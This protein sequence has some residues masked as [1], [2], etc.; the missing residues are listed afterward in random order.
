M[1]KPSRVLGLTAAAAVAAAMVVPTVAAPAWF[2]AK[3]LSAS[4]QSAAKAQLAVDSS[5]NVVAVWE[6]YNGSDWI[7]Q[8]ARYHA[9]SNSWTATADLSAPGQAAVD[10]QVAVDSSGNAIAVWERFNG[11]YNVVQAARFD[12][13]SGTW[14]ATADLSASGQHGD[15]PSVAFS[16]S[17]DAVAL[18]SRGGIIQSSTFDA[19]SGT[20]G[21]AT[22][23][24]VPGLAAVDPRIAFSPSGDALGAW[25]RSDGSNSIVR[26]AKYS[27]VTKTWSTTAALSASGQDSDRVHLA[28]D[29]AGNAIAVWERTNGSHTIARGA[30][31][32]G[33][34]NSW[35]ATE[36]L[37]ASGGDAGKPRVALD[38]SGNAIA[39][40]ERSDG[41]NTIAQ[42]ARFNGAT[43]LWSAAQDLSA[44]GQ[45]AGRPQVAFDA[46]GEA[47][48]VWE[49][50][51][52]SD[53]RIQSARFKGGTWVS[54][55]ELSSAGGDAARAQVAVDA[56]GNAIAVWERSDGVNTIVQRSFLDGVAPA[57]TAVSIPGS[58]DVGQS[59]PMSI[60]AEDRFGLGSTTWDFGDGTSLDN[61][62]AATL[63][64]QH[65]YGSPG[66]Y[67][68]T[69]T[70]RDSSG[71]PAVR[72]GKVVVTGTGSSVS[73]NASPGA[74]PTPQ[75]AARLRCAGRPP[76]IVGT[77]G[78]DVINGTRR[79][80]VIITFAGNDI[81]RGRGG[82]DRI[83]LGS[84]ND[85]G[86]GGGGNDRILGQN[87]NDRLDGGAGNDRLIGGRGRD[88]ELGRR[89]NDRL[90]GG[91]A[92]DRL[93]AGP[94]NDVLRGGAGRDRL[95]AGGGNDRLFGNG[96]RD[97]LNGG[98]GGRDVS[99]GG[100]GRDRC[101]A[102][103]IRR[104]C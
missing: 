98:A 66:T 104:S 26:W 31:Y 102:S 16:P 27:G 3:D 2:S 15:N 78:R 101:V 22:D 35:S 87:G 53:T 45:S 52:G 1:L 40:W 30:R 58:A 28:F 18:W 11:A 75:Q 56:D 46:S 21:A 70:Q 41:A 8:A 83:C 94:G 42:A 51:D 63:S 71:E 81:V 77:R 7:A 33:A 97:I 57:I 86:I 90:I 65:A 32:I 23:I 76:T 88:V 80:D 67:T 84:G 13:A 64:T 82:S 85:R 24:S 47:V 34:T 68:V 92:N 29:G 49:R 6:R 17:G 43:S 37:S 14:G 99:H 61:G 25:E 39:V 10:A 36:D 93:L 72:T 48:A 38:A 12:A 103:R 91:P 73:P 55:G 100:A 4:G 62:G 19:G 59:V 95:L 20:W 9:A 54:G 5:G 69:V 79:A 96:G 74:A 60:A 50:S 44:P 89:G